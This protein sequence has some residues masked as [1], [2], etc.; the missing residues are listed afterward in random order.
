MESS[1]NTEISDVARKE[2]VTWFQ[3]EDNPD[4]KLVIINAANEGFQTKMQ[5]DAG[6][7]VI[8]E[9]TSKLYSIGSK[10]ELITASC[11][12]KESAAMT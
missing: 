4:F 1:K 9:L 5:Q 2:S 6:S 7:Y 10:F 8:T 11:I 12:G 3:N